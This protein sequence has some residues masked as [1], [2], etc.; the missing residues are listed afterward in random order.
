MTKIQAKKPPAPV[1]SEKDKKILQVLARNRRGLRPREVA[2]KLGIP[3]HEAATRLWRLAKRGQ[4]ERVHAGKDG[5]ANG[6]G[7]SLYQ[8]A[9]AKP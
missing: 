2:E 8:A 6:T 3:T 1:Q 9:A 4:A 5:Q 7:R